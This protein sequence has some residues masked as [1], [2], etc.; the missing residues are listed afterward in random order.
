L[1]CR[2]LIRYLRKPI[3]KSRNVVNSAKYERNSKK[4]LIGRLSQEISEDGIPE[5][6]DTGRRDEGVKEETPI[7]PTS[8][9]NKASPSL[10]EVK[11]GVRIVPEAL[12]S[13]DGK[14]ENE[15]PSVNVRRIA[16]VLLIIL[17]LIGAGLIYRSYVQ[18][19]PEDDSLNYLG[20]LP[21]TNS[22]ILSLP[23]VPAPAAVCVRSSDIMTEIGAESY[24]AVFADS[25]SVAYAQLPNQK[26]PFASIVKLLG[27]I[28]VAEEY[29]LD[30]AI[31]LKEEVDAEGNGID[32]EIGEK[33]ITKDLLGAALVGSKNDAMY[34][35]AQN[36]SGGTEGF[37]S[38]LK[39]KAAE[40]GM[41]DTSVVNPIG[42]D[43]P[44]QYSTP[45]DIALLMIVAMRNPTIAELTGNS[46]Y[47]V[48]TEDGRQEIV[49]ATN[50]LLNDVP[51]VIGG[52]T[53]F[54]AEAGF[55]LVTYV[56]DS[57]DFVT[58]VFDAE[59]RYEASRQLIEAVRGGYT[60][61]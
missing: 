28:I 4:E 31:A 40:I 17:A 60:C 47:T 52:K 19:R 61:K 36:Y 55:S 34:A 42:L 54:T 49:W 2:N 58:V 6:A 57:P 53:G 3:S 41:A 51:G 9:P 43:D 35:L 30:A 14:K 59:D 25:F 56:H 46:S 27:G 10:P 12:S 21:A 7:L 15:S 48:V 24:Y 26:A 8:N 20:P 16:A 13:R 23:E 29:D 11:N 38:R 45:R 1:K 18:T 39:E 44:E 37:V 32:L 33:V 50:T 5:T 22:D